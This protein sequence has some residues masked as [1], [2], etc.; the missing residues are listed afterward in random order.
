MQVNKKV[1]KKLATL[2]KIE[3]PLKDEEEM[4]DEFN[5]IVTFINVLKKL[6]TKNIKELTHIH[7]T[8]NIFREDRVENMLLKSDMLR[9]SP[10]SNSDY[11]KVPKILKN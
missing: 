6:D 1:L 7:P 3:I 10:K 8:T 4:L 11:I 9:S 2:S 5:K